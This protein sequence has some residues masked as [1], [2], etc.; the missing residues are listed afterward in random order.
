M[1]VKSIKEIWKKYDKF[2]IFGIIFITAFLVR[3][4]GFG[5]HPGGFNQDEASIGYDSWALLKYGI[6]RSGDSFPVH[7]KAWGSG[8]NAL[9]A[10]LS[11][12]FI[13]IFGLSVFSIRLVN[14]I[15]SL[16]SIALLYYTA[17][18]LA[19]LKCAA[20][21]A[22]LLTISPWNIMLSRWS[23]ES[24]LF[25]SMFCISICVLLLSFKNKKLIYLSTVLFGLSMYAYGAAY[26]VIP[27]FLAVV[28]I[29]MLVKKEIGIKKCIINMLIFI[30]VSAPILIFLYINL[31]DHETVKLGIFTIPHTYGERLKSM[32]GTDLKTIY[33]NIANLVFLQDDGAVRNAFPFYGCIYVFSVFFYIGGIKKAI[34][35]KNHFEA[36][37][38]IALIASLLLF[39]YYGDPNVNRVN[40]VY[41]PLLMMTV[42]GIC[43]MLKDGHKKIKAAVIT[44]IYLVGMFGFTKEYFSDDYKQNVSREFYSSFGAAIKKADECAVDDQTIHVVTNV[45]MPYIYC[46]FYTKT[47]PREFINTVQYINPG[48][49]FQLVHS[50]GNFVFEDGVYDPTQGIFIVENSML[51]A[52][53]AT[54]SQIYEFENYSVVIAN[55]DMET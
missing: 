8:Q 27:L 20:V 15:F 3:I 29:Y 1:F 18:K 45:N 35:M 46:L 38:I 43:E 25:P 42:F 23:L 54:Y 52:F 17:N 33:A 55:R 39:F 13:A 16:L 47:P 40:A 34:R 26:M 36:V 30:A 5:I 48:D 4:I 19:G 10:Y 2:I 24:N 11:M 37:W 31:F 51:P 49:Q 22:F 12:P 28:Y 32:Y 14:L 53:E 21:S 6:D 7:L 44:A 9:Y 50:F 41:I